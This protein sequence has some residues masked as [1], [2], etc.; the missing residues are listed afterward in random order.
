MFYVGDR[1]CWKMTEAHRKWTPPLISTMASGSISVLM[2]DVED[3]G[4]DATPGGL[5]GGA[6]LSTNRICKLIQFQK[7]QKDDYHTR[8][9]SNYK[10]EHPLSP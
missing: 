5:G 7:K 10:H 9:H 2:L 4:C 3:G 6:P 8:R 1:R